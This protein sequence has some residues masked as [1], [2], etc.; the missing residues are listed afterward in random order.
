MVTIGSA[1]PTPSRPPKPYP[2]TWPLGRVAADG[3]LLLICAG[4]LWALASRSLLLVAFAVA[5]CVVAGGAALVRIDLA[6]RQAIASAAAGASL[7]VAAVASTIRLW[8]PDQTVAAA[9]VLIG[10]VAHSLSWPKDIAPDG[11]RLLA[12]V[13]AATLLGPV[14]AAWAGDGNVSMPSALRLS[15]VAIVLTAIGAERPEWRSYAPSIAVAAVAILGTPGVDLLAV[16]LVAIACLGLLLLGRWWRVPAA[17]SSESMA[18]DDRG[19]VRLRPHAVAASFLIILGW[20]CAMMGIWNAVV[21]LSAA[22]LAVASVA[23][24]RLPEMTSDVKRRMGSL[25]RVAREIAR[26]SQIDGLTKLP[27]RE[28]F[29]RRLAEECERAVRHQQPVAL[30]F[31]DIDYFKSVNDSLGHGYGDAVLAAVAES[32]RA[33]ART[34]DIVARYGGEE[35]VVIAPGTWSS[36]AVV[37]AERLRKSVSTLRPDSLDQ[38]VTISVGVA[39]L[40]EHAADAESLLRRADEALYVAKRAGRDRTRVAPAVE[41]TARV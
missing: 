6:P 38:P 34:I 16:E 25:E 36:D 13:T 35:F 10:A 41:V 40:P 22:M 7:A 21:V 17:T 37:L 8:A 19:P 33:A 15:A 14:W 39:G 23:V 18:A 1:T 30:C 4:L 12:I 9:F 29:E 3:A 24:S 31:I 11:R 26:R 20:L 28:A 32:L 2:R 27:N 5:A